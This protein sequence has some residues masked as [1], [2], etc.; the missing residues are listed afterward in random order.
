MGIVR[1]AFRR[2]E[3]ESLNFS[4]IAIGKQ[5]IEEGYIIKPEGKSLTFLE[6][7]PGAGRERQPARVWR[8]YAN[9]IK[10]MSEE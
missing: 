3:D 7:M 8:F 9:K 5:L 6:R 4:T 2:S 10:G 1:D